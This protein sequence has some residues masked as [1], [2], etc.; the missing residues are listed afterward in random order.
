MNTQIL[1][2]LCTRG[3]VVFPNQDLTVEVGR[4]AS[5]D[6]VEFANKNNLGIFVVSQKS[7]EVDQ[8][9]EDDIFSYGTISH[10][11]NYRRKQENHLRIIFRGDKV[12]KIIRHFT[13]NGVNLVEV[14]VIEDFPSD[15]TEIEVLATKLR[16]ELANAKRYANANPPL[17]KVIE[18]LNKGVTAYDLAYSYAQFVIPALIDKQSFLEESSLVERLLL[19]LQDLYR[20]QEMD[21]VEQHINEIVKE[22]IEEGQKEYYLREKL[23]A[24]KEELNEGAASDIDDLKQRVLDEPFPNAVKS[25]AL[26]EFKRFEMMPASSQEAVVI[27]SYLDWL[28]NIPW[29]KKSNDNDDLNLASEILNADHYGLEKVKERILEYL[30]VKQMTNSLKSPIICLVGPPGVGKTSLARSIARALDREFVKVSLGGVRDEAEIRGH[31]RTYIGA[32]PGRI[33]QGMKKA[34]VVNPVFLIDEIDKM[35]SDYKGDPASA[36][37]EV[38][39]PEQNTAF[40]DHYIEEAYDL[41]DVLFVATAN[42][43]ENIPSALLDRLEIINL[44]SYTEIEK[45]HIAKEHLIVK[46]LKTNGLK[47]SQFTIDDETILYLIRHYTREA[48]VRQ[49]ERI[50]GSLCRKAVLAIL[51]D[52]KRSIKVTKK[53]I[54]EWLGHEKYEYGSKEKKDQVGVVTGLA[55]TSF[56]GDILPIEVNYFAG[57]GELVVTGQLGDVMKESTKIALD[58]IKANAKKYDIDEAFFSKHDIHIHVPEGAVPKDGPSAGVTITTALISALTGKKVRY[59]L[60][61]TGEVTL[62]GNVLAIGGL[63]EKSLAAH[64]SGISTIC[65][66]KANVKDLDD[67]ADVVKESI[68]FIPVESVDEVIKEALVD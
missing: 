53:R 11:E 63:K 22:R 51:K 40:S 61:M 30:A 18:R 57:K 7:F 27:R 59:D 5:V 12:G 38:L 19:V 14:E 45:L 3:A 6:A 52:H 42:Y 68:K 32:M 41:S 43:I 62:R 21:R 29:Y 48:G 2:L 20:L 67:V 64:R 60:A 28:L 66:P 4:K 49:L 54:N 39:D 50:F 25:K 15:L 37:L 44:S 33:I 47:A 46:Q 8:P 65:F 36:M 55:Y 9:N 58:Y 16:D 35:A 26:E 24:I 23:K 56:G 17:M 10:I 1:P 34:G 31:R 13:E